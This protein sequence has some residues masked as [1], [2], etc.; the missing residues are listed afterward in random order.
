[1][2]LTQFSES[3]ASRIEPIKTNQNNAKIKQIIEKF[4]KTEISR[5]PKIEKL[6]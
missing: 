3:R 5:F 6:T 2:N 4:T 1:M